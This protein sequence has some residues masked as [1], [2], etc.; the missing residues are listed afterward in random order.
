MGSNSISSAAP[1]PMIK[2]QEM[3]AKKQMS[4]GVV[5]KETD[6]T[7]AERIVDF[8]KNKESTIAEK[9]Y[10]LDEHDKNGTSKDDKQ[11]AIDL[12]LTNNKR[13]DLQ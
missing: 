13:Y 8:Y 9:K 10:Y 3:V 2:Y 7:T 1:N 11:L 5:Y 6:R 4:L 12:H